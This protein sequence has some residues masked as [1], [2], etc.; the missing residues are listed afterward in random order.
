MRPYEY[1]AALKA[2]ERPQVDR[3]VMTDAARSLLRA[4]AGPH[5]SD[6]AS[7]LAALADQWLRLYA[8]SQ[9]AGDLGEALN[10]RRSAAEITPSDALREEYL[11]DLMV[12]LRVRY[13]R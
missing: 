3:A 4:P 10:A 2:G 8:A 7:L 11:A 5:D 1:L 6:R 12:W 13:Q 9:E